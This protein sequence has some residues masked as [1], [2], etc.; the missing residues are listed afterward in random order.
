MLKKLKIESNID[1]INAVEN[2]IDSIT[3]EIGINQDSY[4]KILIA[5]L[6]AVNNA[7]VH[8]NKSRKEKKVDISFTFTRNILKVSVKD[9]G[10]GF[11][12]EIVPDPTKPENVEALNGRGI[13]L[14]TKL[15]DGVKFNRK[16]NSVDLTFK[17]ILS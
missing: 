16:G 8:G 12:P 1:N 14:M 11:N 10:N 6:E 17:N 3:N 7:I 5:V 13:F 9:E 4:G 15:A 2:A